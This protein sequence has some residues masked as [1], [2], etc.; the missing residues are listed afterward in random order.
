MTDEKPF[1]R[2]KRDR[3]LDVGEKRTKAVLKRLQVLGNCA[4]RQSYEYTAE[5]VEKIFEAIERQLS[6]VRAKFEQNKQVD[7]KLR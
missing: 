3:F 2:N 6:L 7:F 4:N 5:D 1:R